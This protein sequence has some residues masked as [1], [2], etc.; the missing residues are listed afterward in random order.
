MA[1]GATNGRMIRMFLREGGLV[2][3]AG[4]A[5]GLGGALGVA[6]LLQNQLHGVSRHDALTLAA[7]STAIVAAA[8]LAIWLPARRAAS[9]PAVDALR[10]E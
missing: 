8:T 10:A 4:V 5:A 6:R 7:S 3:G 9:A 1:L 2:L